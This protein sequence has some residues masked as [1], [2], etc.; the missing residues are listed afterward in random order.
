MK[1]EI[2]FLVAQ[3]IKINRNLPFRKREQYNKALIRRHD[4]VQEF[5]EEVQR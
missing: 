4:T 2:R 1:I 3:N 5:C